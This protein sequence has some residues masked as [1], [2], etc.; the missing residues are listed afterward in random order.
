MLNS[1][2]VRI[3]KNG[4][5]LMKFERQASLLYLLNYLEISFFRKKYPKI[6]K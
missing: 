2:E 3:K 5:K 6:A 4:F 1:I